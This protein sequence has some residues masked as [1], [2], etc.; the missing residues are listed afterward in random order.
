M[1]KGIQMVTDHTFSALTDLTGNVILQMM[2][3]KSQA[4]AVVK[5]FRI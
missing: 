2:S 1:N 5:L 3:G 4:F